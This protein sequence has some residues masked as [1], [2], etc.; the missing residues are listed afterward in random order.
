MFGD[1]AAVEAVAWLLELTA[2]SLIPRAAVIPLTAHAADVDAWAV[3]C[4]GAAPPPAEADDG[5]PPSDG[6]RCGPPA[7]TVALIPAAV[8]W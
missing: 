1:A 7:S 8:A 4:I 3:M 2:S 5:A 6:A